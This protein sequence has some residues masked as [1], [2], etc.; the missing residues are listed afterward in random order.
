MRKEWILTE[1]EKMSK[2]RRI[3]E[4]R[5]L[6]FPDSDDPISI[7]NN[8][9]LQTVLFNKASKASIKVLHTAQNSDI[10]ANVVLAYHDSMKS[11]V[12]SYAWSYPLARKITAI[13]QI[14]NAKSTTALRL[15]NFYKRLHDFDI[16]MET[17]KINLIKNNLR[18][19]LFF[20]ASLG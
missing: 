2:K 18:C 16:L 15:I 8:L 14:I 20:H 3:E 9:N 17:D 10:I 1:E 13:C 7:K 12:T 19:I 6:R 11:D 5:K 4:N